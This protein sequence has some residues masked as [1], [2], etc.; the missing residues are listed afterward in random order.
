MEIAVYPLGTDNASITKEVSKVFEVLDNCDL[1]Y[2]I[3]T[4][5]TIIE[6]TLDE[7]F[8]LARELHEAVFSDSV[9]RVITTIKLDDKR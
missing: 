5:G 7:L 8:A 9:K 3:T 4:M 6:G 2:Q 1:T